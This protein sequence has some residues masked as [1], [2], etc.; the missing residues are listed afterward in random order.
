MSS[1]I[2][3][4]IAVLFVLFAVGFLLFLHWGTRW[5]STLEERSLEMPGDAYFASGPPIRVIMTRAVSIRARP[6]TIWPWLAQLGRGAGWYSIDWLDNGGKMSARHIISWV[7][8]PRLGDASPVGYLRHIEP[9]TALVW[10][11]KGLRFMGA[12]TRLVMDIRLRPEQEGARLVIRMS[13]DA[14]GFT[15]RIALMVFQFI[16]SIMA[17]R[18]LLGIRERVERFGARLADSEAPETGATDQYQLYEVIYA[19]GKRA[20]G[21]GKEHAADWRQTAIEDGVLPPGP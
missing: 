16:D 5:G 19:A 12:T 4:F 15:A 14:M 21:R 20:G 18:Q 1:P 8:E 17:R 10:W 7:P 13:A 9:G 2:T 3:I 6:E 11:L